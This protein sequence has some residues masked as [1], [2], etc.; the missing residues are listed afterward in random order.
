MRGTEFFVHQGPLPSG[1]AHTNPALLECDSRRV[2]VAIE[3]HADPTARLTA[4]PAS[5]G[6]GLY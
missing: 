4:W 2:L 6:P 1:I 5:G 3:E